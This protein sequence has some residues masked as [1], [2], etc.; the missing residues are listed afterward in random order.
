MKELLIFFNGIS[1]RF[2]IY[3]FKKKENIWFPRL[4]CLIWSRSNEGNSPLA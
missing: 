3:S 4:V 2:I 1:L